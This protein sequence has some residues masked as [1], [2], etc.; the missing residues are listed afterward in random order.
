MH[1]PRSPVNY[2]L[3]RV[4]LLL[5]RLGNPHLQAATVHIARTK[6]KGSTAAMIASVLT[7]AG[8]KTGLFTSPHLIDLRERIRVDGRLMPRPT[9][10]KLTQ[11]LRP[12]VEAI[13]RQAAY[14]QLT[15]FELLAALGFMY[16]A[17]QDADFQV[18]EVGLGGRLDATNVVRPEVC[19]IT[20]ISLDHTDVLGD[21]LAKIAAEKAGII[22]KGVPLVTAEQPE[23]ARRVITQTAGDKKAPLIEVGRDVSCRLVEQLPA[24][25]RL[26]VAGRRGH[27]LFDLPLLG[28]FQQAN[29]A[30]AVGALEALMDKGYD[31]APEAVR[32][33]MAAVRWPGRFQV[34]KKRPLVVADGAHNP[35]SAVEL[36]KTL[37]SFAPERKPRI[38]VI[39]SSSDKDYKGL[40]GVLGPLFD[41]IVVT[42][43]RHP[44]SLAEDALVA[45]FQDS[46][47]D[48]MS[49]P[50][51]DLALDLAAIMAGKNGLVC[52]AGSLFVVGEALEWAH[53]RA[54]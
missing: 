46:P 44:R 50:S 14:G 41:I 49:A 2:D 17:E 29:A 12:E 37:E 38:L 42:R 8:Y 4:A 5:E 39:G 26:E 30:A 6:G 24:G 20:A 52:A 11:R 48:V 21:T 33:G 15:T 10:V 43:S 16:F 27:Y 28:T 13:N 36:K 1:Q 45:A 25:Q 53:R 35:A 34:L 23:E 7:A 31:V 19:V 9:L 3:R 22:K 47:G 40:A 54:Y 32:R 18:V 51:V